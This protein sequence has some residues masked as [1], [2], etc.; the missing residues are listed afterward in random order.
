M[1]EERFVVLTFQFEKL[2]NSADTKII[3]FNYDL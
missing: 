3:D 1:V 2:M